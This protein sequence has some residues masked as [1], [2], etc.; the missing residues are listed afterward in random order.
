MDSGNA[1]G[2]SRSSVV[3]VLSVPGNAPIIVRFLGPLW[4]VNLH[5]HG[6]RSHAC[7][8]P[9][10]CPPAIHRARMTWRG[11]A[12]VEGLNGQ[13]RK[14]HP[15]LLEITESLEEFLRGRALRGE[16]W[17]LF[18]EGEGKKTAAVIG[19]QLEANPHWILREA[20]PMEPI[21]RRLYRLNALPPHVD[22]PLPGR[23]ILCESDGEAPAMPEELTL[24]GPRRL[25]NEELQRFAKRGIGMVQEKKETPDAAGHN[26]KDNA[27]QNGRGRD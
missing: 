20:F 6:G 16:C 10:D 9:N 18:R 8:G 4:G 21:L 23:V 5:W 26:G 19:K 27:G 2:N 7:C 11:Y 17:Y 3:R 1:R 14:W 24:E 25:S 22:N 12:C 15:A 13:T